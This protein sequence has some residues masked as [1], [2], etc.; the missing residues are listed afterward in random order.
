MPELFLY[1]YYCKRILIKF[2]KQNFSH[3][4]ESK[5]SISK[6]NQKQIQNIQCKKIENQ[7]SERLRLQDCRL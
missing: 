1:T 3:R 2:Q 4:K 6:S 7:T 5:F